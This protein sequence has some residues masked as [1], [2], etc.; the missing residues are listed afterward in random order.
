MSEDTRA[1]VR[2]KVAEIITVRELSQETGTPENTLR[3]WRHV[4]QGP[5]SFKIGRRVVYRREDV[6]AWLEQAY[7]E[8]R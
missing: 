8:A 1:K 3:W 7:S 5:V 6:D 4:G 2:T